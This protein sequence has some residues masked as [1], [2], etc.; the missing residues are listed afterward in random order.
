VVSVTDPY[1]RILGFLDRT[2]LPGRRNI[3]KNAGVISTALKMETTLSSETSVYNKRT[4]RHIPEDG[5]LQNFTLL[6]LG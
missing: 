6:V 3:K 2:H 5:I 1:G 4:K